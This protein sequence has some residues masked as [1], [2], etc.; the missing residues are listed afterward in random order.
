[1]TERKCAYCQ[2]RFTA[3]VPWQI[4]CS[5]DHRRAALEEWKRKRT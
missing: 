1:M 5:E 2:N 4:Y 3:H